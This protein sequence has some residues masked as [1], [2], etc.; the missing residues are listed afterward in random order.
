[1]LV[2]GGKSF[3]HDVIA[4][5]LSRVCY[6]TKLHYVSTETIMGFVVIDEVTS[7]KKED[8]LVTS[9]F[10]IITGEKSF[11]PVLCKQKK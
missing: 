3:H 11:M 9:L 2:K 5:T 7:I 10:T 4:S 8:E 6:G 1:M